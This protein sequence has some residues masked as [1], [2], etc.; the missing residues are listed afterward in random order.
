MT[1]HL[2]RRTH[3]VLALA[4]LAGI[5]GCMVGPDYRQPALHSPEQFI[6]ANALGEHQAN[7]PEVPF[8]RWWQGFADPVLDRLVDTAL[9]ENLTLEQAMARRAQARAYAQG[10]RAEL[11]PVARAG[12][13]ASHA[14]QSLQDPLVA[15]ERNV[16]PGFERSGS[17][18]DAGVSSLWEIDLAGGLRRGAQAA[19][20]EYQ[21]A[22]AGQAAARIQVA[23][24]VID[25]YLQVRLLQAR[26]DVAERQVRTQADIEGLVNTLKDR[27]LAPD[28]ELQQSRAE[29]A[30]SEAAV[31]ALRARLAAARNHL[32]VLL[33]RQP[34][35]TDADLDHPAPL[36]SAPRIAAAGGSAALLR[37]RPDLIV[38]ERRL[39]AANERI[40]QALAEYYPKVSLSALLGSTTT[41][42]GNLL[43]SDAGK[44]AATLGLRWRLFDFGRVDAEVQ[45]AKGG[46]AGQLAEYRQRVLEASAEVETSISTLLEGE[47][48]ARLLDASE[49]ARASARDAVL[50]SYR[51]GN[52]SHIELLET[53]ARLQAVQAERLDAEYAASASAVALYKALGGGWNG[54]AAEQPPSRHR[55]LALN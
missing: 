14:R 5:G 37:R 17:L 2:I 27:G 29:L 42:A 28:R 7:A 10:A 45:G 6:G 43:S 30:L 33:G 44:A 54:T 53:Q 24:G 4:A 41:H 55:S 35:T 11:F 15:T 25:G 1:R 19:L 38:A 3:S 47:R 51:Q 34:G 8:E 18:Y 13:D 36:P 49:R 52:A 20:A 21:A 22:Q 46:Y 50:A 31:P 48:R 23:A 12:V 39:A 40:G 9:H 32:D 16:L 26:L